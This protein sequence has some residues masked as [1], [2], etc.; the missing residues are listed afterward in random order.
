MMKPYAFL[1]I[2][3]CFSLSIEAQIDSK[4]KSFSIPAVESKKDTADIAPLTPSKPIESANSIGLNRPKVAPNLE[5]PKKDFSMFPE[6]EFGN[7]GELYSKRLGQVEKELLPEGHGENAGLKED[8]YWGDYRTK[9]KFIYIKYRDYSAIDGDVLRVLV[10]D[11]V[12]K[13]GAY[14]TEGF[15]GFKLKLKDGLNKIDFYAVNEGSSGPNTAEYRILDEWNKVISGKVWAL[16]KGVKV[17]IIII[18]E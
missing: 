14:L 9:S 12:I 10:D 6:E 15:G 13:S 5:M 16:S 7:P 8:A 11:D 1:L 3:I 17:T 4:N 2:L 18:K